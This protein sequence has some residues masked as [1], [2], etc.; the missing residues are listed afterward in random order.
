MI[1]L[2][3]SVKTGIDNRFYLSLNYVSYIRPRIDLRPKFGFEIHVHI[4]LLRSLAT[5]CPELI[6]NQFIRNCYLLFNYQ[7]FKA[8]TYNENNRT[9]SISPKILLHSQ[10]SSATPACRLVYFLMSVV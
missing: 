6:I 3:T 4:D 9:A 7:T 5:P 10:Q 1:K 8:R 2:F